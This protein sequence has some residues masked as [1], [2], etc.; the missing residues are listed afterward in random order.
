MDLQGRL[1]KKIPVQVILDGLTHLR[2]LA[3]LDHAAVEP[4]K[5]GK[6]AKTFYRA[7]LIDRQNHATEFTLF[8]MGPSW[9]AS[10]SSRPGMLFAA[11]SESTRYFE[12]SKLQAAPGVG[13]T[14]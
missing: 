13:K 3:L 6:S 7:I 5:L 2:A 11:F 12:F 10:V 8:S 14:P 4:E 1:I 9:G